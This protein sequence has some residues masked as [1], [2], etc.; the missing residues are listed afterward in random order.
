VLFSC[1]S[2]KETQVEAVAEGN[3]DLP[4]DLRPSEPNDRVVLVIWYNNSG[5]AIYRYVL[6]IPFT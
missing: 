6:L 4:C 2:A 5:N 3:A 1:V